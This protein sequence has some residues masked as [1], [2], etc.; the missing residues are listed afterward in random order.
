MDNAHAIIAKVFKQS[1]FSSD[2]SESAIGNHQVA[3]LNVDNVKPTRRELWNCSTESVDRNYIERI[4]EMLLDVTNSQTVQPITFHT[5]AYEA[6]FY[7]TIYGEE[8]ND[9]ALESRKRA[10][11]ICN[12]WLP[13]A[14]SIQNT[15]AV[16]IGCS[17]KGLPIIVS[18]GWS[19]TF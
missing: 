4:V 18:N 11:D 10:L 7:W 12:R 8:R 19:M 1:I 6:N 3:E 5:A 2:S 16:K 17:L 14:E 13:Y 9:I 15:L